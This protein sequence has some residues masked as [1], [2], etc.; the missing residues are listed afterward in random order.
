MICS[1]KNTKTGAILSKT[2]RAVAG[3]QFGFLEFIWDLGF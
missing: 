1:I 2:L 3:L